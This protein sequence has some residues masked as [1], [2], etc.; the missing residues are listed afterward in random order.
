MSRQKAASAWRC[1][2]LRSLSPTRSA[3][4]ISSPTTSG[5]SSTASSCLDEVRP[6]AGTASESPFVAASRSLISLGLSATRGGRR[7]NMPVTHVG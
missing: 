3:P 5:N 2:S 6:P 1:S 4:F 7:S